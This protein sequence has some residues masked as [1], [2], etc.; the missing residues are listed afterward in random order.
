[1]IRDLIET[2]MAGD[3]QALKN[4][5]VCYNAH[6]RWWLDNFLLHIKG[7]YH[8]S[9]D[10]LRQLFEPLLMDYFGLILPFSM[11]KQWGYDPAV[12]FG[13]GQALRQQKDMM[14]K[15]GPATRVHAITD[16]LDEFLQE[17]EG[18]FTRNSGHYFDLKITRSYN[19]HS[20]SRGKTLS[21]MAIGELHR[22]MLELSV[23]LALNRMAA[24]TGRHIQDE[25]LDLGVKAVLDHGASL[26]DAFNQFSASQIDSARSKNAGA[27]MMESVG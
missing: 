26:R 9:Y 15:E 3:R 25:L 24:S 19:R 22:E 11:T 13:D 8:G 4:K 21:P 7:N 14:I 12:D 6:S 23:S 16:E 5:V 1:M 20:L 27:Q 10:L 2:D 17:R 18:L